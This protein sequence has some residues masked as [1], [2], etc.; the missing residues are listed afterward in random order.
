MGNKIPRS[1]F[2]DDPEWEML[3]QKAANRPVSKDLKRKVADRRPNIEPVR[4]SPRAQTSKE[5]TDKEVVLNLKLS[6]PKIKLPDFKVFYRNNRKKVFLVA[7]SAM[8]LLLAFGGLKILT[9]RDSGIV[10]GTNDNPSESAQEEAQMSFNPL[11]PLPNLKDTTGKQSTPEF[12]YNKEKKFL[13]FV[14]EYNRVTMTISQQKVPD[15]LNSNPAKL[16]SLA[17]SVEAGTPIDTQKGTAYIGTDET[18]KAQ[19]VVFATDDVL[20]FIRTDK[21]LDEQDW[22]F[23][24][25]Q[26]SPRK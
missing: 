1:W 8:V 3:R 15:D 10:A 5:I 20:V 22:K 6:L 9:G 23:Y 7:G 4:E 14:T 25:N 26:L 11:V 16:M 12:K 24:I 17:E 21:D 19:T 2:D 13:R 18:T